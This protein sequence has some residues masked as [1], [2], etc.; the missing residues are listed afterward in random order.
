[1]PLLRIERAAAAKAASEAKQSANDVVC[2]RRLLVARRHL[3][4][5]VPVDQAGNVSGRDGWLIGVE[6]IRRLH[7]RPRQQ[8][9]DLVDRLVAQRKLLAEILLPRRVGCVERRLRLLEVLRLRGVGERAALCGLREVL[10]LPG[11][12]ELAAPE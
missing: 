3:L 9:A 7:L 5:E 10:L 11:V 2:R 1:M 4:I 6:E 8:G 12:V